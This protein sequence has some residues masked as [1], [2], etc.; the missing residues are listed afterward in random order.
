[1]TN[2]E[3]YNEVFKEVFQVEEC[4]LNSLVHNE[5]LWDSLAH[6]V[7]VATIEDRFEIMFEIDDIIDFKSYLQGKEILRRYGKTI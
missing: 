2:L 3:L 1:M 5:G 7:L 6:M 4:D